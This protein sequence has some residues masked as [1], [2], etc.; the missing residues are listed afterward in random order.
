MWKVNTSFDR[1]INDAQHGCPACRVETLLIVLEIPFLVLEDDA[2]FHSQPGTCPSTAQCPSAQLQ[3]VALASWEETKKRIWASSLFVC[4][5]VRGILLCQRN[6]F[7]LRLEVVRLI[8]CL[9]KW[10]ENPKCALWPAVC[11][12][13]T[14]S[15]NHICIPYA[16]SVLHEIWPDVLQVLP[17]WVAQSC[18]W[19]IPQSINVSWCVHMLSH[20]L[21]VLQ[22]SFCLDISSQMLMSLVFAD[23]IQLLFEAFWSLQEMKEHYQLPP[24]FVRNRA[25]SG[26][27]FFCVKSFQ[28]FLCKSKQALLMTC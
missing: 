5:V 10:G 19:P 2:N 21:A 16:L 28:S 18:W 26:L 25:V 24:C 23:V 22:V 27:P 14:W 1:V 11:R 13:G 9:N 6:P 7:L 17:P 12:G 15:C 3:L 20:V 8:I 4:D